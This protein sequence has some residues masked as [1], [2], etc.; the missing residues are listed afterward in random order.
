MSYFIKFAL[1]MGAASLA[2]AS[3]IPCGNQII[4]EAVGGRFAGPSGLWQ[5]YQNDT[6]QS[7]NLFPSAPNGD[8]VFTVSQGAGATKKLDLVA[9][10]TGLPAGQGPY[11]VE[12]QYSPKGQYSSG[13]GTDQIEVFAITRPLPVCH[14]LKPPCIVS[15]PVTGVTFY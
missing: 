12:F 1:L 2:L 9:S 11:Q 6:K 14:S 15:G 10:F 8:A 5:I 7:T 4:L 13:G 3:V